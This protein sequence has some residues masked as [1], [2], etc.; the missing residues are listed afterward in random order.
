MSKYSNAM[1]KDLSPYGI[2]RKQ[3]DIESIVCLSKN[4][5]L[6]NISCIFM[7]FGLTKKFG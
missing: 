3:N 2:S 4:H 1:Y 6:E 7:M 5:S